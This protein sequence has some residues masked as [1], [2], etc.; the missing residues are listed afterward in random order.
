MSTK[1]K[2]TDKDGIFLQLLQLPA[3]PMF[4][5]WICS[6]RY[7]WIVYAFAKLTKA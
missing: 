7:Y 3:G 2:F 6:E 5:K 1:Y 4:L